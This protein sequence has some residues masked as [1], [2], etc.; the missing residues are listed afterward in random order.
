MHLQC[1]LLVPSG[2]YADP[3]ARKARGEQ[4]GCLL[5]DPPAGTLWEVSQ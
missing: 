5:Y 4:A 1:Y 3:E 2:R